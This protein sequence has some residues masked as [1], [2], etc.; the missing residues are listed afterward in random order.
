MDE[1]RTDAE[2]EQ[3][4][5][6]RVHVVLETD[7][8]EQRESDDLEVSARFAYVRGLDEDF[9]RARIDMPVLA[10]DIL[11][12]SDC[13]ASDQLNVAS[14]A[15][16]G[17]LQELVLVDAGDLRVQIGEERYDVPLALVPDLL[18]YMSGVE[19]VMY[20]DEAAPVPAEGIGM[21]VEASGSQTDELP[22]FNAEG[23]VP[24]AL[25]LTLPANAGRELQRDAL[26][27]NWDSAADSGDE[28]I[29]LRVT[30]LL[31]DE[32]TGSEVTCVVTDAGEARLKLSSL[33]G[34]GLAT[35]ADA[36]R[37]EAS[38]LTTRSFDAGDFAGS[39][40]VVERRETAILR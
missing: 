24:A 29:T 31:G 19:Y 9:V 23:Q 27:L 28:T 4:R 3:L 1:G 12:A 33:R 34:L 16:G 30:G 14:E 2:V 11:Q 35:N 38:R 6:G 8:D 5:L 10:N 39:E 37:I 32:P 25:G 13:A 17:E 22:P 36:L 26:V 20:G 7:G 15:D 18:P 40:L 21:F